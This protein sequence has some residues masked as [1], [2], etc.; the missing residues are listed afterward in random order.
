M[1]VSHSLS[2]DVF[3]FQNINEEVSWRPAAVEEVTETEVGDGVME[4]VRGTRPPGLVGRGEWEEG[5]G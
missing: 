1:E 4:V 2:Y 3:P 5:N